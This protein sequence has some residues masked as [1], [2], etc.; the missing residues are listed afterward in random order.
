MTIEWTDVVGAAVA[1]IGAGIPVA[2]A[3]Q[4]RLW[5]AVR[6]VAREEATGVAKN[7][8]AQHLKY[9]KKTEEDVRNLQVEVAAVKADVKDLHDIAQIQFYWQSRMNPKM[10]EELRINNLP[11]YEK[12]AARFNGDLDRIRKR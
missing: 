12:F 5:K 7:V 2:V 4:Q 10:L 6:V 11:L 9:A 8:M 1:I 3:V